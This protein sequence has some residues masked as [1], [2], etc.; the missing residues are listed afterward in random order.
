MAPSAPPPIV[1]KSLWFFLGVLAGVA[2]SFFL[3]NL[4]RRTNSAGIDYNRDGRDDAV[5][6]YFDGTLRSTERDRN[7]DGTVDQR[8]TFDDDVIEA[9]CEADDDFDGKSEWKTDDDGTTS[10]SVRDQ[11]ADA[12]PELVMHYKYG[13]IERADYHFASGGRIVKREHF[14]GGL[15]SFAEYDDD[16]DGLFER[17]VEFD[18]HGEP[19]L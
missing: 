6:H 4:D 12:R 11:D 17:R 18:A 14:M 19:R 2:L 13:V 16:G 10:T 9:V 7:F 3:M 5:Y 8:C 1:R 15:L